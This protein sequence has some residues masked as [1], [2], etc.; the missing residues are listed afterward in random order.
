M[1]LGNLFDLLHT[2]ISDIYHLPSLGV[3]LA[4]IKDHCLGLF[5]CAFFK[6]E[7]ARNFYF[8]GEFVALNILKERF[9]CFFF[10]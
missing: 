4:A 3:L 1:T 10:G 5:F 9:Y 2:F 7:I 6:E 8:F